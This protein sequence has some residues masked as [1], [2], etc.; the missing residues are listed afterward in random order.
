MQ[1]IETLTMEEMNTL[2]EHGFWV[3]KPC[4]NKIQQ[5]FEN[6]LE[7][8][9]RDKS[10][11][12]HFN[13]NREIPSNATDEQIRESSAYLNNDS[14]KQ[15][16]KMVK[17][18]VDNM[19]IGDKIIIARGKEQS[20]YICDITSSHYFQDSEVT[21][22]KIRRRINNIKKIPEEFERKSLVQTL[23]YYE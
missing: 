1:N 7:Y 16:R 3:M 10:I 14:K 6:E 19:Q 11:G 5:H 9:L 17:Q 22:F 23:R 15:S 2:I 4:S 8:V 12:I 21:S 20:L 13:I 18:F